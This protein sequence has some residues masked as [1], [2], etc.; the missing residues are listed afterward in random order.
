MAV[1]NYTKL[2]PAAGGEVPTG[3][4]VYKWVLNAGDTGTPVVAPHYPDKTVQV[5]NGA[6]SY[7]D[8]TVT[9]QGTLEVSASPTLWQ[10]LNDPNGTALSAIAADKIEGILE[11][12]YQI[13]PSV[14][15]TTGTNLEVYLMINTIARR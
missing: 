6:G 7:G 9:I 14:S 8:S 3:V 1:V 2:I 11:N 15:G 13:R 12:V 5:D 4:V 10:T